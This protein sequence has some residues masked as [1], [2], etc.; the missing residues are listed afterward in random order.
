MVEKAKQ[1]P[2]SGNDEQPT[3]MAARFAAIRAHFTAL[4]GRELSQRG[5]AERV[6]IAKNTWQRY[7]AGDLPSATLLLSLAAE[8]IN[9]HWLLTGLGEMLLDTSKQAEA[10]HAWLVTEL[11]TMTGG[12]GPSARVERSGYVLIPRY[13]VAAAAGNGTAVGDNEEKVVEHIA[14]K[15]EWLHR[16]LGANPA[17]LVLLTSRGDSMHNRIHDGD[18]LLVDRSEPKLRSGNPIYAFTFDGLLYVKRLQ[19][20]LDGAV[21]VTSDNDEIYPPETIA[22]ERAADLNIIGRVL[23]NAGR[24]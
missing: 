22:A 18:L 1:K 11:A 10:K 21:V 7:E 8:G 6:G 9:S 13:E 5:M 20:R 15:R 12:G 17:D 2:M 19:R 23:W 14:F 24:V 16:V 4:E 3:G